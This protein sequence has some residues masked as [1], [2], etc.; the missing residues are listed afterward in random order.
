MVEI[1][2]ELV[3]PVDGGQELVPVAK[4]VL[5][6]L[7]GRVTERLKQLG[8]RRVF[9][10][11]SESR[12]GEADLGQAGAQAG[13]AGNERRPACRAAL[14]GIVIREHHAFLGDAVDVGRLVAHHAVRVGADVRLADVI[15]P[16]DDDVGSVLVGGM[17]RRRLLP[18]REA[19][20]RSPIRPM[21]SPRP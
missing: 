14:L 2:V 18:R 5:A 15:A 10:L 13:L 16:D 21:L 11:Q 20:D 4:M 9:L 19:R 12:A 17:N 6:E 7:P 8:N 3:E 1:A